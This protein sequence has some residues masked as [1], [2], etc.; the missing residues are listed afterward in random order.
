MDGED[1][2][3]GGGEPH[4]SR[5]N[6]CTA[7][8]FVIVRDRVRHEFV[9]LPIYRQP[10][11]HADSMV[12]AMPLPDFRHDP[13]ELVIL[14]VLSEAPLYG[15]AITKRVVAQS[16]G[17][18]KLSPGVLYPLLSKME[19]AGLIASSWETVRSERAAAQAEEHSDEGEEGA[20]IPGEGGGRRRKWYR[21]SAKGRKRLTQHAEAHRAYAA[22]I[23]SFLTS[24]PR[25]GEA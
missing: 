14:A 12:S 25:G 24:R 11:Y 5:T 16:S 3:K 9:N 2:G 18:I 7:S 19:R 21:L 20:G 22:M 10:I 17:E 13:N 15:Y 23:D 1:E 8:R 6:L 4:G